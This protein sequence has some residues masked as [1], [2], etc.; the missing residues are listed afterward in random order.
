MKNIPIFHLCLFFYSFIKNAKSQQKWHPKL[1]KLHLFVTKHE[2][3]NFQVQTKRKERFYKQILT[4]SGLSPLSN[5]KD[6]VCVSETHAEESFSFWATVFIFELDNLCSN[7]KST[8]GQ[9][10][11]NLAHQAQNLAWFGQNWA[12][13]ANHLIFELQTTYSH[14]KI[15]IAIEKQ[16]QT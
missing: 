7:W 3:L 12:I 16:W 8:K 10:F 9:D 5:N 1:K 11:Q 13:W 2:I 15:L 6:L 4:L 14:Q